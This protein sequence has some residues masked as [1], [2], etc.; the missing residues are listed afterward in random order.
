M[1][2]PSAPRA[3]CA[4]ALIPP[5][6]SKGQK[7]G[8]TGPRDPH[9]APGL[10]VQSLRPRPSG[11]QHRRHCSGR[12]G[13][14]ISLFQ[15]TEL[16]AGLLCRS[17]ERPS[18]ASLSRLGEGP[19]LRGC[20]PPAPQCPPCPPGGRGA[21]GGTSSLRPPEQERQASASLLPPPPGGL[22]APAPP[23][24]WEDRMHEQHCWGGPGRKRKALPA[25]SVCSFENLCLTVALSPVAAQEA[26]SSI[27]SLLGQSAGGARG[28]PRWGWVL[29]G[30][31][32]AQLCL[33][34]ASPLWAPVLGRRSGDGGG[35]VPRSGPMASRQVCLRR[36]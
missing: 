12:L 18:A 14:W 33:I 32:P 34:L 5:A 2:G 6:R 35:A 7:G 3:F 11:H 30:F 8:R 26:S 19:C 23:R 36:P 20:T 28:L 9:S 31:S 27:C 10:W 4:A 17:P 16:K 29:G 25:E 24:L 13:P 21:L 15:M 1:G 22:P